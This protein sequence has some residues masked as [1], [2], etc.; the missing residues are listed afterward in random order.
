[1]MMSSSWST[2]LRGSFLFAIAAVAAPVAVAQDAQGRAA[3][4]ID[5]AVAERDQLAADL[6]ALVAQLEA[7]RQ[8][9]ELGKAQAVERRMAEL[10]ARYSS[11]TAVVDDLRARLADRDERQRR[12]SA[13]AAA[14]DEALEAAL[15]EHAQTM[16]ELQ[17]N[18]EQARAEMADRDRA[19]Q[20]ERLARMQQREQEVRS[21]RQSMLQQRESLLESY[22]SE[23]AALRDRA[24]SGESIERMR[25]ELRHRYERATLELEREAEHRMQ[26]LQN[27][28]ESIEMMM[29][30]RQREL[31]AM[32]D[33]ATEQLRAEERVRQ[34]RLDQRL[35]ELS[36]ASRGRRPDPRPVAAPATVPDAAGPHPVL[37]EMRQSVHELRTEVNE[38]RGL[39]RRLDDY[40]RARQQP[41]AGR[42]PN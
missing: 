24:A 2:A 22:E 34:E 35:A 7:Y 16:L 26:D 9:A 4:R 14:V 39:V 17:Q 11:L 32:R 29:I 18:A 36:L 40:V 42:K 30:E 28:A 12:S 1:M 19:L 15:Q 13:K 23:L 3:E 37:L 31:Q 20:E 38:L 10:G 27:Q 25:D 33:N 5:A 6:T 21:L 41:A 8:Q